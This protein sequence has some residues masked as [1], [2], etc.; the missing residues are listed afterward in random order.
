MILFPVKEIKI[1]CCVKAERRVLCRCRKRKGKPNCLD[2]A[3]Y[4]NI[5]KPSISRHV[6]GN[7]LHENVT[8]GCVRNFDNIP[9]KCQLKRI[10]ENADQK[11]IRLLRAS[12]LKHER[13][14]TRLWLTMTF[15]STVCAII[16]EVESPHEPLRQ[17]KIKSSTSIS[18]R[19]WLIFVVSDNFHDFH[20]VR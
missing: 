14:L 16:T 1:T 11:S 9:I 6:I 18:F 13:K 7:L 17:R 8:H 12:F 3:D 19:S 10:S 2:F 5:L 20:I 15:V 4:E